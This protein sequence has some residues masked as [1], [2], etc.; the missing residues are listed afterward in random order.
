MGR[1]VPS[2]LTPDLLLEYSGP[3]LIPW[4]LLRFYVAIELP[5]AR[6]Y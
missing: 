2:I 1:S 4:V 3:A 5:A 6:L